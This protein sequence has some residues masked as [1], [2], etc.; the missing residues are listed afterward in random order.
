MFQER[1]ARSGGLN[2]VS[3]NLLARGCTPQGTHN[4]DQGSWF[5]RASRRQQRHSEVR[6]ELQHSL[7]ARSHARRRVEVSSAASGAADYADFGGAREAEAAPAA[8]PVGNA[9]SMQA[10]SPVL[11]PSH[12]HRCPMPGR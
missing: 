6:A 1:L 5:T 3:Q 9:T 11:G 10:N 4:G 12:C 7:S 8:Q 2:T